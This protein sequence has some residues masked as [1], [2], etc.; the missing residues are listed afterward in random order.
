MV[1]AVG[2]VRD[3]KPVRIDAIGSLHANVT[4]AGL[5][6]PRGDRWTTAARALRGTTDFVRYWHPELSTARLL[7]ARVRHQALPW[8]LS[9]LDRVQSLRPRTVRVIMN[10]LAALD[11]SLPPAQS[12]LRFL[13]AHRPDLVLV[14]PLVEQ[15]RVVNTAFDHTSIIKT[16]VNCFDVRDGNGDPATLLAREAAATDVSEAVTL[17]TPRTDTDRPMRPMREPASS[18]DR[19]VEPSRY[20]RATSCSWSRIPSAASDATSASTIERTSASLPGDVAA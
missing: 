20:P 8:T 9:V 19:S 6:P 1:I 2:V 14:S 7:R 12:L 5:V 3:G 17:T 11:A 15:G 13:D 18:S 10:G 4:V 16:V